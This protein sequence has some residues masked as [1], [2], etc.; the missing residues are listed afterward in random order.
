M[1][2]QRFRK[3]HSGSD[4]LSPHQIRILKP[5]QSADYLQ[6][7]DLRLYLR[8]IQTGSHL[9]FLRPGSLQDILTG[10]LQMEPILCY[11]KNLS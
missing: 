10:I 8:I 1:P 9:C 2:F 5:F 3:L 7:P 6:L 11:L 4:P